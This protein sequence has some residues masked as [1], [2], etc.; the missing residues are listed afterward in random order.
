MSQNI[1]SVNRKLEC[2][3]DNN[4][5]N[6]NNLQLSCVQ[7]N[8]YEH[9]VIQEFGK[10]VLDKHFRLYCDVINLEKHYLRCNNFPETEIDKHVDMKEVHR[11]FFGLLE[12]EFGVLPYYRELLKVYF[13]TRYNNL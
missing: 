3:V 6:S 4:S 11:K 2:G 1:N 13:D 7:E 8:S 12:E 5:N 9:R 10:D